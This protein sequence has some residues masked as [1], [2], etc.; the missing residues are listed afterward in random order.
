MRLPGTVSEIRYHRGGGRWYRHA[1][2]PGVQQEILPDGSVRLYH[3]S[4]PVW[5]DDRAPDFAKHRRRNPMP[6]ARRSRGPTIPPWLLWG[7]LAL[8][9]LR[10]GTVTAASLGL[11]QQPVDWW[12]NPSTLELRVQP[13]L[14]APATGFRPASE[15]E[16][17]TYGGGGAM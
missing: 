15:L 5:A 9:V 10:G 1:F 16:I 6:H 7:G 4:R 2:R 17:A 8:L 13:G 14:T 3:E 11:Q 12:F